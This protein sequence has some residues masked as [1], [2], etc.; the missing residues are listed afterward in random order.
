MEAAQTQRWQQLLLFVCV[1]VYV[2]I[3]TY[4]HT[5]N[6]CVEVLACFCVF[7]PMCIPVSLWSLCTCIYCMSPCL[8]VCVSY[9][10]ALLGDR[11]VVFIWPFTKVVD[12]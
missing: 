3:H 10:L 1:C 4:V 8:C 5:C 9:T 6:V 12:G 7:L 2:C 11:P